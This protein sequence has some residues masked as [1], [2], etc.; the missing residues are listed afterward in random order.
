MLGY[1]T[2]AKLLTLSWSCRG[3]FPKA[4]KKLVGA[5]WVIVLFNKE[6][7]RVTGLIWLLFSTAACATE[8]FKI[9]TRLVAK[10]THS[11]SF[12]LIICG[13]FLLS[14][15]I[16]TDMSFFFSFSAYIPLNNYLVFNDVDGLYT[17]TFEAERKVCFALIGG[18]NGHVHREMYLC[19]KGNLLWT[20]FDF[21]GKLFR[22]QPGAPRSPVPSFCQITG[23]FRVLDRECFSVSIQK[24]TAFLCWF[25]SHYNYQVKTVCKCFPG[26]WN[27]QLSRRLWRGRTRRC[28]CR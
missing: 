22:V 17:Y 7:N 4:R 16:I 15:L 10:E 28:I 3:T 5:Y 1:T 6:S 2:I 19:T 21:A 13:L 23:G 18:S 27:P 26:K 9:A 11:E 24:R 8:V 25:E 12:V 14:L 20:F